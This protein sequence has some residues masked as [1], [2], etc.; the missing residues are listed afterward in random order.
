MERLN[1]TS[2]SKEALHN[3]ATAMLMAEIQTGRDSV[4]TESD[5]VSEDELLERLNDDDVKLFE[6]V[7]QKRGVSVEKLMYDCT[8]KQL[9]K[10]YSFLVA[11]RE[12]LERKLQEA[13]AD[14]AAGNTC[15]ADEVFERL[16]NRRSNEQ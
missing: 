11:D 6:A 5:W 16:R 13:E 12:D 14:I 9:A 2:N 3:Q 1:V 4:K 8:M 15:P 7:A 10:E